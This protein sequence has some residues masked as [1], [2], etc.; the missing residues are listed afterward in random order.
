MRTKANF[1]C[2]STVPAVALLFKSDKRIMYFQISIFVLPSI[3]ELFDCM[4]ETT[5]SLEGTDFSNSDSS[6]LVSS[7]NVI[8]A[9]CMNLSILKLYEKNYL[10]RYYALHPFSP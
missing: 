7:S 10:N 5:L 9:V 2:A 8:V 3:S 1:N 6:V 4:N